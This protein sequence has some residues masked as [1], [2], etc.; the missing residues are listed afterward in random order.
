[1]GRAT[2]YQ[3][4][5]AEFDPDI[6]PCEL[7]SDCHTHATARSRFPHAHV[8]NKEIFRKIKQIK[9]QVDLDV[10]KG[11]IMEGDKRKSCSVGGSSS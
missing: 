10:G 4:Q 5:P 6:R 1:M 3:T 9:E 2:S 8:I 11:L 7:S